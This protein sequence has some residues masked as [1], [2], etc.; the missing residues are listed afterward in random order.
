MHK[1]GFYVE[2]TTVPFMRDAL[3]QVKPPVILLHAQDRGLLHEIRRELSPDSFVIGRIF[4]ETSVQD[5]WLDSV[6]PAARGKEFAEEIIRYDF[7]LAKEKGA[8]GRLLIDAWMSLNEALRGPASFPNFAVDAQ[9]RRRAAAYDVFQVA[10][11]QRLKSEGLEAVAF[12][13]A[14]G[15]FIRPE[16]Y[17]DWYAGTLE[18]Y[19]YLGF[20]EYGW[21][22]LKPG[23]G[24]A[25]SAGFYR[26]CMEGIRARYG[27]RHKVIITEAGLTQAYGNASKPDEGWLNTTETLTEDSYWASLEWYNSELSRDDYAMGCCM[28]NVGH[29]GRWT[30]F[31]HLGENNQ[32]QAILLMNR[33]QQLSSGG[34]TPP[35]PP[36]PPPPPQTGDKDTLIARLSL[37]TT[38]VV[39]AENVAVGLPQQAERV[40]LLMTPAVVA[41]GGKPALT[42]AAQ[43]ELDRLA[44]MERMLLGNTS[45]DAQALL[46]EIRKLQNDLRSLQPSFNQA[47]ATATAVLDL[48]KRVAADAAAAQSQSGLAASL[49]ALQSDAQ[50]LQVKVGVLPTSGEAPQPAMTDLRASLPQHPDPS[51][52]YALRVADAIHRIIVHHTVTSTTATPEAIAQGQIT[53]RNL[54]GISYHFTVSSAGAISW[55]QPLEAQAAQCTTESVNADSIGVALIGTFNDA[56]P[57]EAQLDAAAE[58][59]AWLI[60]IR[61]LT[62]ADVKGRSEVERN[63]SPGTQWLQ[64]ARYKDTLLAKVQAILSA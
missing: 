45:S 5:A 40:Q 62:T 47:D 24:V 41:V 28:F 35:P 31:R 27:N 2:Q 1:L 54:P 56:P 7:G 43:T 59:I 14:A 61:K 29:S 3:R 26:T 32:G 44:V 49:A 39:Q 13:F 10:F 57:V 17:L 58:L 19:V 46:V 20:H 25:T 64:G 4:K 60:S 16:H 18:T 38:A 30:S 22:A 11:Y 9:F 42:P 8:N 12:N 23:Q 52:R 6:D 37:L 63:T 51:K 50:T 36:P 33:I 53:R 34:P 15:N 48:Q 55:T 21:P